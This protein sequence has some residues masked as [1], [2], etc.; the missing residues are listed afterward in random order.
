[1]WEFFLEQLRVIDSH[2]YENVGN[3]GQPLVG[4]T[5]AASLEYETIDY[6]SCP[7]AEAVIE[8]EGTGTEKGGRRKRKRLS[9]IKK[10]SKSKH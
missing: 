4:D 5:T 9:S 2:P 10:S 6:G 8:R 1:M 7:G 3:D